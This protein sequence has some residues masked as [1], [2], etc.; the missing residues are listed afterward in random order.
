MWM[1]KVK[2]QDGFNVNKTPCRR[3]GNRSFSLYPDQLKRRHLFCIIFS[4]LGSEWTLRQRLKKLIIGVSRSSLTRLHPPGKWEK[5]GFKCES[6]QRVM[7]N[8]AHLS[9]QMY[10]Q[11]TVLAEDAIK[12]AL[13]DYK[14]KKMQ[15]AQP[16]GGNGWPPSLIF[17]KCAY[18]FAVAD[19]VKE[20]ERIKLFL[21]KEKQK[22]YNM[23]TRIC[24]PD[25]T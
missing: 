22:A 14:K 3:A 5:G 17:R 10:S 24:T 6:H 21:R 19:P 9:H 11:F 4:G 8:M 7:T 18:C 2:L 16:G 13:N 12:A 15:Q 1:V 20:W 23:Q 25:V